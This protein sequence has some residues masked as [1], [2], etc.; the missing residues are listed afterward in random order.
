[1][2]Q[3]SRRDFVKTVASLSAGVTL[4]SASSYAR[5]LGANERIG[6][7][8][9]GCGRIARKHL[10]NML[11]MNDVQIKALCDVYAPNLD[12]SLAKVEGALTSKDYRAVLDHKEVDAILVGTPDHWHALP[13]VH[14]CQAGKDVYVEKPTAIGI[15]ESRKMVDAARQYD[16]VVQ[17][18]TQQRSGEHFRYAAALVRAGKIGKVSS[19][20]TWNYGNSYPNGIGSPADSEPPKGLD[21][22]MWLGPAP[23]RPFNENRFGVFLGEEGQYERWASFRWFWDYAGGMMTD[24][25]STFSTL[26]S[27]PWMR[28]LPSQS[29]L[30]E[31]SFT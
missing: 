19:V 16:R 6:V 15:A 26:F 1:M 12:W 13:T 8:I 20:R 29:R 11:K 23:Q 4:F 7:G 24:W 14:A 17:V 9:V 18:G 31:A 10:D 2:S 25:E 28:K 30:W 27:G 21:W 22:D 5:I 3:T